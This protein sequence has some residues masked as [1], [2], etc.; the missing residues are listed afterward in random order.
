L[1]AA[2]TDK[3]NIRYMETNIGDAGDAVIDLTLDITDK[4]HLERLILAMRKVNGVRHVE[5]IYKV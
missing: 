3:T 5:R 2:I 4:K 1:T